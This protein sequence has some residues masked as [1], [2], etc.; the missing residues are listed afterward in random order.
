MVD[1]RGCHGGTRGRYGFKM[2]ICAA[3]SPNG[4]E[5]LSDPTPLLGLLNLEKTCTRY[6]K[7]PGVK[8]DPSIKKESGC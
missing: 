3:R 5:Q 7:K 1:A 4:G 6:K 8:K 2:S